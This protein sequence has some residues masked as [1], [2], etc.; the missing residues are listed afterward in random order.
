MQLID[1]QVGSSCIRV[2]ENAIW[3]VQCA[4]MYVYVVGWG[5][6]LNN[7]YSETKETKKNGQRKWVLA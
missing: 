5:W 6:R 7:N 2:N 4:Y 1:V 3:I